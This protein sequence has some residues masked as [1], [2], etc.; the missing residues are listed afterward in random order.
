MKYKRVLTTFT[1]E[2]LEQIETYAASRGI[3]K[4]TAVKEL[5]IRGLELTTNCINKNTELINLLLETFKKMDQEQLQ[6]LYFQQQLN[7]ITLLIN[8]GNYF[9]AIN[10]VNELKQN[11]DR[12][13]ILNL[14]DK[15]A[16]DIKFYEST[17]NMNN[18]LNNRG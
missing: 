16:N 17:R 12:K 3:K 18:Y 2:E 6:Q 7:K 11:T 8:E 14:L 4:A 10:L 5:A 15:A 1:N 13:D 9:K